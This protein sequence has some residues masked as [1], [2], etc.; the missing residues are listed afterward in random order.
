MTIV[1]GV[2]NSPH[3]SIVISH[4]SEL[5]TDL[6]EPLHA[7]HVLRRAEFVDILDKD[8]E[9]QAFTKNYEVRRIGDELIKQ[10]TMDP[11]IAHD[12]DAIETVIRVGDPAEELTTYAEEVDARYLVVGGRRRSPTGKALFS[13]VTQQVLLTASMPTLNVPLNED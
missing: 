8:V 13:S 5:A 10:A 7:V 4:A 1:A 2:D 3:S 9:G 12:S 6:G 11:A